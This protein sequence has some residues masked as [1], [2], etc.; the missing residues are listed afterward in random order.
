LHEDYV[1]P[2]L[3]L[4]GAETSESQKTHPFP[5][6]FK[7]YLNSPSSYYPCKAP[8]SACPQSKALYSGPDAQSF[9][10][11]VL[12]IWLGHTGQTQLQGCTMGAFPSSVTQD[13]G[14]K[15]KKTKTKQ[16]K[17]KQKKN[18]H[19]LYTFLYIIT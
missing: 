12:H 8:Q 6:Y 19:N 16:N 18:N 5:N 10:E 3:G 2:E 17:T 1:L 11:G 4:S 13:L 14:I 7:K 15:C 9:L